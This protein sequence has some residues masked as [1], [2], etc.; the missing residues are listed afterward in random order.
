[1][2]FG[3]QIERVCGVSSVQYFAAALGESWENWRFVSAHGV[4]VDLGKELCE[5]G[6]VFFL[7][8]KRNSAHKIAEFLCENQIHSKFFVGNRLS[9]ADEKIERFEIGKDGVFSVPD[10]EENELCVV[11]VKIDFEKTRGSLPDEEFLRVDG[12][13]MTKR[14][15]R[16][17]VVSLLSLKDDETVWDI[18]GGTGAISIDIARAARVCVYCIEKNPAA[19]E[20]SRKNRQKFCALNLHIIEG[21]APEILYSLPSPDV[22]FIGGS[23]GSFEEIASMILVKNPFARIVASCVTVETLSECRAFASS[24]ALPFQAVQIS[25]AKSSSNKN[26]SLMKAENPVWLVSFF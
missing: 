14:V 17:A 7:T 15:V 16:S 11:L 3:W 18:G 20:V 6:N 1:M 21:T 25:V 23:G 13:P 22:A 8:D 10:F 12:V 9:Y 2:N 19:L 5:G 24:R 4:N 26:L